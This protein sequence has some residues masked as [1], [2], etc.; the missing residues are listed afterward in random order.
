MIYRFQEFQ[1]RTLR[2]MS[3]AARSLMGLILFVLFLCSI[4]SLWH[5]PIARSALSFAMLAG[6]F[7]T[8]SRKELGGHLAFFRAGKT[9]RLSVDAKLLGL[10]VLISVAVNGFLVLRHLIAQT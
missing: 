3:Y 2:G 4:S 6:F 1:A 9:S 7:L 8:A 5:W 10:E